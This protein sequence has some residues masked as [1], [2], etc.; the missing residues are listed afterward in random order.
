L[1]EAGE[2]VLVLGPC[3][4]DLHALLA[5]WPDREEQP[6]TALEAAFLRYLAASRGRVVTHDEA[7]Q[8]VWGYRAGVKSRAV[9]LLVGRLRKKIEVDPAEPR[10]LLTAYGIGF[11]LDLSGEA[12]PALIGREAESTAVRGWISGGGRL[13]VVTGPGGV[14]K[15]RLVRAQLGDEVFVVALEGAVSAVDVHRAVLEAIGET[16]T[17]ATQ[18]AELVEAGLRRLGSAVVLLDGAEACRQ[19]VAELLPRWLEALPGLRVIVTSR[20]RVDLTGAQVQRLGPLSLEAARELLRAQLDAR[21]VEGALPEDVELALIEQLDGLPL[22]IELAAA[23]AASMGLAQLATR[24]EAPLDLLR[25]ERAPN[26][27]HRGLRVVFEASWAALDEVARALLACLA[28]FEGGFSLEAAQRVAGVVLDAAQVQAVLESLVDASLV[29]QLQERPERWRLLDTARWIAVERLTQGPHDAAVRE[30]H[31]G[32]FLDLGERLVTRLDGAQARDFVEGLA[33]ESHN[34]RAARVGATPEL[35]ARLGLV[36]GE[37]AIRRGAVAEED[38]EAPGVAEMGEG[39]LALRVALMSVRLACLRGA[40][41][42]AA[43]HLEEARVLLDLH[44]RGAGRLA[45]GLAA[46]GS[47][48]LGAAELA[49]LRGRF[50]EAVRS[51][52]QALS[53]YRAVGEREGQGIACVHIATALRRRGSYEQA[54]QYARDAVDHL[55]V[56]GNLRQ[57][58]RARGN[59]GAIHYELGRLDE[60]GAAYGEADAGFRL[61]GASVEHARCQLNAAQLAIARREL[62]EAERL[63]TSSMQVHQHVGDTLGISTAWYATGRLRIEQQRL[64]EAEDALQRARHLAE[65]VELPRQV[66]AARLLQAWLHHRLGRPRKAEVAYSEAAEAFRGLEARGELGLCLLWWSLLSH[67]EGALEAA[68]RLHDEAMGLL[69]AID[70]PLGPLADGVDDAQILASSFQARRTWELVEFARSG[71]RTTEDP[72]LRARRRHGRTGFLR[73][74]LPLRRTMS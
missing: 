16:A 52:Q 40:H 24:I 65:Q 8:E 56:S 61:L 55:R 37:L 36:L 50:G 39:L 58:A 66:A 68:D 71:G 12:G 35:S 28:V 67:G 59:L 57:L 60:A 46:E 9:S 34:L 74:V 18:D 15:S 33:R 69:E 30:A 72:V 44:K 11:R 4:V 2:Q 54:L 3:E 26:A 48:W 42:L 38:E 51:G 31:R 13:L 17:T 27:R 20:A 49:V 62:E 6:L 63:I 41:E 7:L 1:G 22:A 47:W 21:E 14:G 10:F 70:S 23:R 64:G 5:R 45:R 25:D 53:W 29:V 43:L 32:Y 73:S 19:A